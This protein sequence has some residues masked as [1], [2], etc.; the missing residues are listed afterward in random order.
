[1]WSRLPRC[2]AAAALVLPLL[3][4]T[5]ITRR[6]AAQQTKRGEESRVP[7]TFTGG[8]ETD[9][10]DYGRPV[11]LIAAALG[12]P[13]D[14][15]REAFR[16]VTPAPAGTEPQPDQVRRNK[17]ALLQALGRYGVTNDRLDEVSNYYRY[18][19]GRGE[20]WRSTPA[21]ACA[22]V[23]SGVVTGFTVTNPGSGYSSA[24]QVSVPGVNGVRARVTLSFSKELG[25][26]G[27]IRSITLN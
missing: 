2:A 16:H 12:V 8:Y 6:S 23:R 11:V 3:A 7:V 25:R 4:A 15:F 17:A 14:V 21:S 26:N 20:M 24:P 13:T 18:N 5:F 10:Q 22:I 1:M 19:R 27:A 9:P